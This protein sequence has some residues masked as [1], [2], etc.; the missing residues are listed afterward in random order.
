M[1][2]TDIRNFDY[3]KVGT[4]DA[5]MWRAYY[6]HQF[7][8]LF[9]QLIKL[10]RS[11]LGVNWIITAR[12]AYYSTNAATVYRLQ[13]NKKAKSSRII[14]NLEK[15]YKLISDNNIK[16]FGYQKAA[17]Y[18]L[19]WWDI[20]RR[21]YVNN[22][23]LELSIAMSTSAIYGIP[24]EKLKKYA[25]LRAEAMILPRH[26]DDTQQEAVDWQFIN[27]LLIQSWKEL[28]LAVQK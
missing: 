23:D 22:P 18:E 5:E 14:K 10:I 20:H 26:E 16:P 15:F 25:H 28:N 12:L 11:Q 19:E 1:A 4:A 2:K 21:S 24:A 6:N 9:R 17:K 8:K 27:K 7:F 3:V 13:R